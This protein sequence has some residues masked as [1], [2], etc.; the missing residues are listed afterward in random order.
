MV[1]NATGCQGSKKQK[2]PSDLMAKSLGESSFS[3]VVET[4]TRLRWEED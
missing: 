4:K 3:G 1:L 2:F